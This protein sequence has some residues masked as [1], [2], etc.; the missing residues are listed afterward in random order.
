MFLTWVLCLPMQ[1]KG[2]MKTFL[3]DVD[4]H[5]AVLSELG[6]NLLVDEAKWAEILAT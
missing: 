5:D 3:L 4:K 1:G 6:F 2:V